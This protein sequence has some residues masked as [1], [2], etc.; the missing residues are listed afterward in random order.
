MASLMLPDARMPY[1]APRH[2]GTCRGSH[3]RAGV[4]DARAPFRVPGTWHPC[5]CAI[6]PTEAR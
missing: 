3:S 2:P 4:L 5:L 1:L 6:S